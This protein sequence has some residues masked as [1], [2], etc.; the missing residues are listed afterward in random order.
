MIGSAAAFS[1]D[2]AADGCFA[3]VLGVASHVWT[4]RYD[5]LAAPGPVPTPSPEVSF[6]GAKRAGGG[7]REWGCGNGTQLH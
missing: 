6:I 1:R 2:L 7:R 5:F 4:R 3:S